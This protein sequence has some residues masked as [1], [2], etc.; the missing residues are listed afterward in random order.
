M[1]G[2][3]DEAEGVII[4]ALLKIVW[5]RSC[6]ALLMLGFNRYGAS[7]KSIWFCTCSFGACQVCVDAAFW[8]WYVDGFWQTQEV[9]A[10]FC[11]SLLC[12]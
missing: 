12:N 2:M 8:L 5:K 9:T 6:V 1:C 10:L 7:M 3:A 11:L 4:S